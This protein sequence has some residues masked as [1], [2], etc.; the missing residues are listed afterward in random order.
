MN[1][2]EKVNAF[3]AA[4]NMA[5]QDAAAK[6]LHPDYIQHN[7]FIPTG[8]DGLLNLFPI[9]AEH[10]TSVKTIRL[11]QDGAFVVA[12][13]LWD[14]AE[15]F[16]AKEM[17]S[18]DIFRL[19]EDG[20]IAEHWDALMANTPVNA[21]GRTLL[22]GETEIKDLEKTEENK[23]KIVE[24]FDLFI[25]GKPAD[26]AA[27]LPN[28]FEMDYHQHNPHAGDGIMGFATA[29]Q[30]GQLVFEFKQQHKVMGEGNFVLSISEGTHRGN[31]AVFYDLLR[32]ENG[33]IAEHWDVIQDIPTENLAHEN[34]MFNF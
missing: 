13:N 7:P 29:I 1:S 8:R 22:D 14:N 34:T 32:F 12:H 5:D 27:A 17:I 28:Y 15:A 4:I 3:M 21:S 26:M 11:I 33:K 31:P 20:L 16:G 24:M 6:I 2:K 30:S 10:K 25:H 19:G 9:L 18:F 23:A